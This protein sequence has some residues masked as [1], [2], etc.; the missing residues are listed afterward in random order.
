MTDWLPHAG[1][2]NGYSP[3][4]TTPSEPTDAP[5]PDETPKREVAF[6]KEDLTFAPDDVVEN[7]DADPDADAE[8]SAQPAPV[9]DQ[10]ESDD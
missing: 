7:S 3:N 1:V 6:D 2:A 5:L 9:D 4:M 10:Q 8:A